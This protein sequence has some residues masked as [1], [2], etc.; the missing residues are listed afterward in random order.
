M[1]NHGDA[2]FVT[3]EKFRVLGKWWHL[4]A[5]A[6]ACLAEHFCFCFCRAVVR[7]DVQWWDLMAKLRQGLWC[8]LSVSVCVYL[9]PVIYWT[10]QINMSCN[11]NYI[12]CMQALVNQ[13]MYYDKHKNGN[14]WL[15]KTTCIA[16]CQ[17]AIDT[18]SIPVYKADAS[19]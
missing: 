14:I 18:S 5:R 19:L 17:R 4:I 3:I 2:L 8:K 9:N 13:D 10:F 7:F 16:L 15:V 6:A 11:I 12:M 1:V